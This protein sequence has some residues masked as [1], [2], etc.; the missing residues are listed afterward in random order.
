MFT[1]TWCV[2]SFVQLEWKVFRWVAVEGLNTHPHSLCRKSIEQTSHCGSCLLVSIWKNCLL[3]SWPCCSS[4]PRP[5]LQPALFWYLCLPEPGLCW[6][7]GITWIAS[8]Q[9]KSELVKNSNA[10]WK[11]KLKQSNLF[12]YVPWTSLFLSGR[13]DRK[14]VSS[15]KSHIRDFMS[16]GF[17]VFSFLSRETDLNPNTLSGERKQQSKPTHTERAKQGQDFGRPSHCVARIYLR[18]SD[19][20]WKSCSTFFCLSSPSCLFVWFCCIAPGTCRVTIRQLFLHEQGS[21]KQCRKSDMARKYDKYSVLLCGILPFP[22][23]VFLRRKISIKILILNMELPFVF[24][25]FLKI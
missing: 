7:S 13:D 21:M 4:V 6:P 18:T 3:I 10:A 24:L 12:S 9:A 5:E 22:Q 15:P 2:P 8:F 17:L 14:F 25:P 23:Y 20:R 11:T 16:L 19:S 1:L